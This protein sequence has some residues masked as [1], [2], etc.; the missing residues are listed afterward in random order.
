MNNLD[1]K[2]KEFLESIKQTEEFKNYQKANNEFQ[3]DKKAQ[4]LLK[5]VQE[6][7]QTLSILRDGSFE[8]LEEQKKKTEKLLDEI[9]KNKII[10]EWIQSRNKLQSLVGELAAFLSEDIGFTFTPP[11]KRSC[12]G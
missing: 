9:R 4:E 12:C 7:E 10:N 3:S 5:D 11:Q 6:A 8:G 1:Q 2:T